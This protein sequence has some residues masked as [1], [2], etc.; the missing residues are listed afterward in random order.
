[1]YNKSICRVKSKG[2]LSEPFN[3]EL[4]VKQG[5]SLSSMLF[6]IYIN[7]LPK[8]LET[9]IDPVFLLK[10]RLDCLM[11][12]DDLVLLSSTSQGLQQK[13]NC[14]SQYCNEWCL[15]VNLN[16]TNILIFNKSGKLTNEKFTYK[17]DVVQ[18][19]SQY[20]YLGL[21]FT[22]SGSLKYSDND[23]VNKARKAYFKL[24]KDFLSLNP[25]IPVSIHVFNHTIKP[26]LLYGSEI[27]GTFQTS[28]SKF[29]NNVLPLSKI[30]ANNSSEKFYMKYCKNLLGV[31]KKATNF[32]VQSELGITP[33]Y[34]DIV[35]NILIFW[36]RL[37]NISPKGNF[38]LLKDAY[39]LSKTL[40]QNGSNSWFSSLQ[41][42]RNTLNISD[43]K[44]S[45][46]KSKFKL[47]IKKF[48][49][50]SALEDWSKNRE[51]LKDGKLSTYLQLKN[52]FGFEHY[53][54]IMDNVN[55]RRAISQ[56]R[57]SCHK[58]EVEHGRYGNVP[59]E[60]RYCKKCKQ[61]QIEDECHFLINCD[62]HLDARL[63]LFSIIQK[64]VPLF[65]NL[66]DKDKM[67]YLL[68]S[69]S[70][71]ILD[72]VGKFVYDNMKVT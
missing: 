12:A 13:L 48:M 43:S 58:L 33:I 6:N 3:L 46:S 17:N 57:L 42:L 61:N 4:G 20:K 41:Y 16:K 32:G 26:I 52:N 9:T 30:Y 1:M 2:M 23:L 7:D 10:E 51:T 67:L 71:S 34:Y 47:F 59:R 14:L 18:N 22:L 56:L 66:N 35:R 21:N 8:H 70:K 31:H 72:S 50:T 11:Y 49:R 53:L 29:R 25:N 38:K 54:E 68:N 63:N 27:W 19:A 36:N 44:S 39:N 69:E 64:E 55:H 24:N 5:D 15:K 45:F 65:I 62:K 40:H 28:S 37:E 60:L